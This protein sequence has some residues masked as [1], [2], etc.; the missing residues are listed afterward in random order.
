VKSVIQRSILKIKLSDSLQSGYCSLTN[1][2]EVNVVAINNNRSPNAAIPPWQLS[3]CVTHVIC[4]VR[5]TCA[6]L[7]YKVTFY[8]S[9]AAILG[10]SVSALLASAGPVANMMQIK[11]I[12]CRYLM[13]KMFE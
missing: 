7:N 9:V 13:S 2:S 1:H 11:Q 10:I 12:Q 3:F 6:Q 4:L 5:K 8:L